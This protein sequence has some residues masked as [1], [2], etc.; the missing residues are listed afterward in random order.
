VI[1]LS[2]AESRELDRLSQ[3]DYG[4]D[5]YRLM[6]RAGEAVAEVVT[7]RWPAALAAGVTV[8]AGKGNNGGDG[9]VAARRLRD[10]GIGV[11]V[12]L[13]ARVC[14]LL[15]DAARACSDYQ[16]SGGQVLESADAG[17]LQE[18]RSGVIIDA[19]FGTGLNAQVRGK[20][21][22]IIEAVNGLKVPVAAVDIA[23][24][25]NADTGAV[26]AATFGGWS[27]NAANPAVVFDGSYE[28]DAL[29]IGH[30]YIVYA[31]PLD[32]LATGA[33][34][35]EAS[36]GLCAAAGAN[37][38]TPPPVNTNFTTRILPQ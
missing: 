30:N 20:P 32:G 31:E 19:L 24:G 27:C 12:L 8:V 13:L 4:I 22:A 7:R 1:L 25:V 21:R 14:D 34:F 26:M 15:G 17:S 16:A 18:P 5:S 33:S 2:A 10:D 23:S 29:P 38:C 9:F 37:A 11:R 6:T 35:Y 28:I 3:T 36:N